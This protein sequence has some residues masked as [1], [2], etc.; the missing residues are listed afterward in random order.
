MN[1]LN[2][3]FSTRWEAAVKINSIFTT[4]QMNKVNVYILA[5]KPYPELLLEFRKEE[6]I[7]QDEFL[8][9]T[10]TVKNII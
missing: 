1:I 8:T 3:K 2:V 10:N 9:A 6:I 7:I 4:K 5:E